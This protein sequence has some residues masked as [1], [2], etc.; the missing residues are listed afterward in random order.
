MSMKKSHSETPA[1]WSHVKRFADMRCPEVKYLDI[2][3][4]TDNALGEKVDI[5]GTK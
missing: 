2:N 4:F 5:Y 1:F 3:T